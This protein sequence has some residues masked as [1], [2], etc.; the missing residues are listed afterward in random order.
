MPRAGSYLQITVSNRF[1]YLPSTTVERSARHIHQ[2]EHMLYQHK[3]RNALVAGAA[4]LGCS[5]PA[6]AA[7]M[8]PQPVHEG[9]VTY[10]TGGIGQ[11]ETQA[12]KAAAR[13]YDLQI[14]NAEKD[15]AYTAGADFVIRSKDG[16]EVLQARNTGPLVYAQLPPGDYVI[17]ANYNGVQRVADAKIDGRGATGVHLIWPQSD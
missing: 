14:S 2:E 15:G 9:T 8:P 16:H 7:I 12:I 17:H 3:I 6:F 10:I 1:G 5:A 13:N 11:A 4:L